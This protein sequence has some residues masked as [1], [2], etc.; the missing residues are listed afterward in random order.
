M[1]YRLHPA[2]V[3]RRSDDRILLVHVESNTLYH[4]SAGSSH[5]FEFFKAARHLEDFAEMIGVLEDAEKMTQLEEFVEMLRGFNILEEAWVESALFPVPRIDAE[6]PEMR[7]AEEM[8]WQQ[9]A[10]LYP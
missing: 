3:Y 1:G 7:G 9:V 8:G 10:F 5:F 4:F 6:L 2:V